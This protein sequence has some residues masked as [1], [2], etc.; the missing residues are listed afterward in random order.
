VNGKIA[1]VGPEESVRAFS[2]LGVEIV[3][4]RTQPEALAELHRLRKAMAKDDR[5]IERNEYAIVFV[6]EHLVHDLPREDEAK[7]ASTFLPAIIP[8]P[9]N[10]GDASAG[11]ERLKKLVERAVGSDILQ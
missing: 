8:T 2:L 5:G 9:S 6:S 10:K 1:F 11:V 4:A 7:F 3:P